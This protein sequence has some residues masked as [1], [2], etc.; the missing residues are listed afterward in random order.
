[1]VTR[2]PLPLLLAVTALAQQ[3]P[4]PLTVHVDVNLVSVAF[5]A[6]NASGEIARDLTKDYF[7]VYEDGVRQDIRFFS[8]SADLPLR[9]AIL[10]DMSGSQDKF[11]KQH[12]RDLEQFLRAA[13]APRDQA[14]IVGFGNRVRALGDF[15][16]SPGSLP[17]SLMNAFETYEHG[18]S[19]SRM[20]KT[21]RARTIWW[22]P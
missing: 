5:V 21:T 22:T 1:M 8:R 16:A 11:V 15:T 3:E 4:P 10:L 12:H 19:F 20:A 17:D 18:S 6:R 9:L 7:D 2:S 14:M 13:I